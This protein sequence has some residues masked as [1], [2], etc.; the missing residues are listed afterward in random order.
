MSITSRVKLCLVPDSVKEKKIREI[1]F[2]VFVEMKIK[3]RKIEG[4]LTR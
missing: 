4:R 3:E 2:S 1:D